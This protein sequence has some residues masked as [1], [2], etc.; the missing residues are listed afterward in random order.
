[1]STGFA[2]P[3]GCG[4]MGISKTRTIATTV[5][6]RVKK[7]AGLLSLLVNYQGSGFPPPREAVGSLLATIC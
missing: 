1:M 6:A 7:F 3:F 4:G 5:M 2:V